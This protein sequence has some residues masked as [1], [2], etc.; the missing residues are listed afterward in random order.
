MSPGRP[1]AAAPWLAATCSDDGAVR[2]RR[3]R[4][5]TTFGVL[6]ERNL[7]M[8]RLLYSLGRW[9]AIH[10]RRVLSAWVLLLAAACGLGIGLHGQLSSVFSVPGT[11]SQNAQNLLPDRFPAAAGGTARVVFAAPGGATLVS[12]KAEDAIG[13]SLSRAAKVPGVIGVSDPFKTGTLSARKTIGY[14]D[15]LF[16]QL[17]SAVPQSAKNQ[18]TSAI[19]AFVVRLTIIP[20]VMALLGRSA[21]QLPAWLDRILPR[22]D[23]EGAALPAPGSPARRDQVST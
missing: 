4:L 5:G 12:A 2:G 22:A 6:P 14:A 8:A 10:R 21:W 3:A 19:D 16:R 11:E 15:V 13:A 7:Q 23:I 20:A 17:G 9:A 1:V 18:L